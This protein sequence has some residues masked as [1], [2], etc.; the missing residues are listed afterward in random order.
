[1]EIY[2]L[3]I[4]EAVVQNRSYKAEIKVPT[5]LVHSGG[6]RGKSVPCLFW[7]LEALLGPF[8]HIQSQFCS[9]SKEEAWEH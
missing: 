3:K 4:W 9:I 2:S 1:M 7:L 6:S 5:G 8:L